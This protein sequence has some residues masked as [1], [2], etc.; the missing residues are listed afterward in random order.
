MGRIRAWWTG[1][2]QTREGETPPPSDPSTVHTIPSRATSARAVS[3]REAVGLSAVFRAV[4]IRAI[5]ARQITFDPK[6][7]G[8]ILPDRPA[9]LEKPD[10][11]CSAAA[12]REMTSV[13][14]D[15]N[16]NAY[17]RLGY[18]PGAVK[19]VDRPVTARVLNPNDVLIDTTRGG[20]VVGYRYRGKQLGVHDIAHLARLRVPGSPYGLGPI[21][22]AQI[23]L[24]GGLDVVAYGSDFIYNGDVPSG[25][26]SSDSILNAE[27]AKLAKQQWADSNGGKHG[28][29]VL[30]QGLK[31]MATFLSP[32]DA[33]FLESQ[34]WTVNTATRLFGV[35]RS[36]M[37]ANAEGNSETY[38]NVEQDWLGFIRFGMANTLT[39][40]ED[41]F[42]G[43][44][45][46]GQVAVYNAGGLLKTDTKTRY[47]THNLALTGK[48]RTVNE[49]RAIEG[50]EPI[51][52]GDEISAPVDYKAP[53]PE[54]N[55]A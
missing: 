44:L 36:L 7:G 19:G 53:A 24:R 52:G 15:L 42:T 41:A 5:A 13:S 17:W 8:R 55:A 2:D 47:E 3:G 54:E 45:P 26:L 38:Q 34:Q 48:W 43:M 1:E 51:D 21:Q 28:V 27:T 9:I 18:A 32:K 37:L 25:V 11:F 12:F 22:A 23:E 39:E 30:G 16:G 4:E 35:P 49:I 10:P 14:L 31:Y 40:I 6:R 29:A 50:L 20:D 46:R 33:Q